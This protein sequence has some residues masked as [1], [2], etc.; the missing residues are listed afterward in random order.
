[1]RQEAE[2]GSSTVAAPGSARWPAGMRS[3][4]SRKS[5]VLGAPLGPQQYHS[6]APAATTPTAVTLASIPGLMRAQMRKG[7]LLLVR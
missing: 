5:T 2:A 6:A 4:Q 1:M 7:A 3:P